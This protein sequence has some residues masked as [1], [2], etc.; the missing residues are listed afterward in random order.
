M[1]KKNVFLRAKQLEKFGT[2]NARMSVYVFDYDYPT[3]W[4]VLDSFN[5]P[6]TCNKILLFDLRFQI[7]IIYANVL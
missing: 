6:K 2:G 3:D 7:I 4:V 1:I 5:V